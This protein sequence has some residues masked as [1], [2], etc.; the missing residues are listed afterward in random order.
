M[1]PAPPRLGLGIGWRPALASLVLRRPD[2]GF[3]EILAEAYPPGRPLPLALVEVGRRGLLIIPHGVGLSL[4]GA[5]LPDPHRVDFLA[6]LAERVGAPLV[7]EHVAFVRAAGVEAGHLLP[8]P[9]TPASL[10]VLVENVNWV[11]ERLPV[12]LAVE[13]IASLFEWPEAELSETEFLRELVERTGVFLLLDVANVYANARN[14]GFEAEAFLEALPLER[15]AYVHVAGGVE[16]GHLYYDTHAHPV[17]EGVLELL[18]GVAQRQTLPGV[19]LERDEDFPP[20]P[21]LDAELDAIQAALSLPERGDLSN[22][23]RLSRHAPRQRRSSAPAAA[24]ENLGHDQAALVR[25]LVDGAPCPSGFEP[26]HLAAAAA[27][28]RTKCPHR[29]PAVG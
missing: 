23:R 7:S 12:P 8:V 20:T 19:M 6:A 24:R 11:V 14:R 15:V 22:R 10:E 28:L 21:A 18:D 2:L 5:E 1:T 3:V 9:R 17:P 4:G 25:A 26:A 29:A 13:P 27:V 16:R